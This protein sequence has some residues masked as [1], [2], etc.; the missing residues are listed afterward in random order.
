M[1][2]PS[3]AAR[4]K[5]EP[6][7]N[8]AWEPITEVENL[9]R[10]MLNVLQRSSVDPVLYSGLEYCGPKRCGRVGCSE[11]CWYGALRRRIADRQAA[12]QLLR[13]HGGKLY[14][15]VVVRTKWDR[16]HGD[17]HE[18]NIAAGRNLVRRGLDHFTSSGIVAVGSLKV[19]PFGF[20]AW[21]WKF[22]THI[23]VAGAKYYPLVEVFREVPCRTIYNV[24]VTPVKNVQDAVD[25][26]LNANELARLAE[27]FR[28]RQRQ[29]FYRWLLNMKIG[30]RLIRYGCDEDFKPLA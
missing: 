4:R 27:S 15:V 18:A 5:V 7:N 20:N 30:S 3:S 26:A 25:D 17:L 22:E 12:S 21:A 10:D 2:K 13:Q 11:A 19:R 6:D 29:E 1:H 9:Q 28:L 8:T 14:D 23:I 16:R 24:V